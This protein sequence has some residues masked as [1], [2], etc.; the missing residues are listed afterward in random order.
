MNRK[1]IVLSIIL[2]VTTLLA[3]AQKNYTEPSNLSFKNLTTKDGLSQSSVI[4]IIQDS[5]GYLWFGTRDGL[6]KFDGTNFIKFRHNS[7]DNNSLSHSWVTCIFQDKDDNIWVGTKNGLNLFNPNNNNFTQ[8]KKTSTGISVSDNQIWDIAQTHD[9]RIIVSTKKG[10]TDINY[11]KSISTYIKKNRNNPNS[12]SHNN[13]R[14]FLNTNDGYLWLCTIDK[15]DRIH[16]ATNTWEHFDYPKKTDKSA[17]VINTPVLFKDSR[18]TIWLG[19]ENGIAFLPPHTTTFKDFLFKNEKKINTG[20]R[21]ISEDLNNN[22]WIGSY[23]GL[24]ILNT[25]QQIF[26]RFTHDDNNPKSLSQNSIYKIIRDSKGDMWIGTWAGGINYFDHSYDNFKQISSGA[27]SN[28]LN[29]KVVSSIL[30]TKNNNL[31]IGTEGGGLNFLNKKTE[32][33]TY[34]KHDPN[35]KNS[36]SSNNIKSMILDQNENLWIGTHDGGLNFL[37]ANKKPFAFV[38]FHKK[39]SNGIDL[40]K[41]RIISLLED[42]NNN[43]WIGTLSN[44]IIIYNTN[45]KS[46]KE[47]ESS[48]NAS[49]CLIQSRNPDFIFTNGPSG[50]SKINIHTKNNENLDIFNSEGYKPKTNCAYEQEDK[51]LWIGTEGQGLFEYDPKTKKSKKYGI[52]EGLLNEV[53]Y[54]I[55]PDNNNHIWLSTNNGIS[56]FNLLTKEIKNFDESDG[57]QGNEFNYGAA[58]K[59][60]N[61]ILLFGG[62]NGLNYFEPKSIAENTFIPNINIT[63]IKVNNQS[64]LNTID[65]ISDI[66]L[67]YNQNDFS[68]SFNALSYSQSNKNQY[69]Y[70][71][72]GF[73]KNWNYKENKKEANYTNLDEGTYSFKVIASNNDGLWNEKGKLINITILPAPWK[74]WWAYTI[75]IIIFGLLTYFIRSITLTRILEKNELKQEKLDKEKLE[76]VNQMK[77]KLFTNISHDFRTPL[78]LII[79]PLQRMMKEKK[80]NSF[81]QE[82]HQI[83]NRNANMLLD[84]IN[85]ILDFR[86]SESG[87]LELYASKSD[88]ITFVNSIKTAFDD[89]ANHKNVEYHLESQFESIDVWFDKIKMKKIIFNLLSNAF[90]YNQDNS[91]ISIKISSE[92]ESYIS[93]EVTNFGEVIPRETLNHVFDRFYRFDQEGIQSGTGIGLALTKSLVELHSG[94]ISVTSSIEKGTCFKVTFPLGEAHLSKSQ[95]ITEN[96]DFTEEVDSSQPFY[97]EKDI[98]TTK[99]DDLEKQTKEDHTPTLLIV[100][101]N[102]DVRNFVKRIFAE[103][104][105]ILEA[106]NGKTAVDITH[107]N[108]IDL[109]ISDVMMPEMNGFELC[110]HIKSNITTSHIPV[111]LLTAKTAEAHQKTGYTIGADAYITKPFDDSILEVRVDNLLNT[112]KSLISKFKKDLILEPK[113][114]AFTSA[115]EQFLE[116]AIKIIEENISDPEFNVNFFTSK[117]NMS[118][119]VL[120]RKLKA[121]TDQSI[122]EFIRTIKLKKAGQL[123]A[124]TQLNI[125]E[126]AYEVGFND[127]KYFRKCFKSQFNSLPS[128]YRINNSK[129]EE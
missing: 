18:G 97:L 1:R 16:L 110:E 49:S 115:D 82:Q 80:G 47:L 76:E 101:D 59:N 66:E 4:A 60:K 56:R 118:R 95:K 22:L 126:I 11:K 33:F 8:I 2:F 35:D 25:K 73:D 31:W 7:E 94:Q 39:Q 5:K 38:K 51:T 75:Y 54:T 107:K 27:S 79:G 113:E 124:Q 57:L 70:K 26:K 128:D 55:L 90:K 103:K 29:Y 13:I 129:T 122:T 87:K 37:E 43:I 98:N 62:T 91:R 32:Q 42:V 28:M 45:T 14:C 86:K 127:L 9:N 50:L 40:K 69:A 48:T 88:L 63:S 44:G 104:Y 17:H 78:T 36:I 114:L 19:Y 64:F 12:P 21:T 108:Q 117:M 116:Q 65:G 120:Y 89:L 30:E 6:N 112:R 111:V 77:L 106:N 123:I 15:V 34:Y 74:T 61:G 121:I 105:H 100:E 92:N 3:T 96:Q 119:S 20:V 58:L 109:I 53:I 41:Y 67:K 10:L 72:I 93:I 84:L 71:L 83:M 68:I 102:E 99:E 23:S 24:H 52:A 85:Q 46:F 81:I 125:S